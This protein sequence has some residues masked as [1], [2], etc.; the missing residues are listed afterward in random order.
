ML[1]W[2]CAALTKALYLSL[3]YSFQ[4]D[5]QTIFPHQTGPNIKISVIGG[6]AETAPPGVIAGITAITEVVSHPDSTIAAGAAIGEA[7]GVTEATMQIILVITIP[8]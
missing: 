7:V 4:F 3:M 2:H 8:P 1:Y 5:P 6:A